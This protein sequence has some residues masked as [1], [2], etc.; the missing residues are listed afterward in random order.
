MPLLADEIRM[1]LCRFDNLFNID[2][3]PQ[4]QRASPKIT[5][6]VLRRFLALYYLLLH[7]LLLGCE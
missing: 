1:E 5:H 4:E 3:T 7:K 2:K 6:G